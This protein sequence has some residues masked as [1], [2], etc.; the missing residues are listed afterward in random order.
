MEILVII[1]AAILAL[2]AFGEN[3]RNRRINKTN[4]HP[5]FTPMK[6]DEERINDRSK[7]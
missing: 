4:S 1:I 3:D 2:F 7:F 5:D 6:L